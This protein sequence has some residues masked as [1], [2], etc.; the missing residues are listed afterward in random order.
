MSLSL[1]CGLAWTLLYYIQRKC[2]RRGEA[3]R[4]SR[5]RTEGLLVWSHGPKASPG[6][7][8][9]HHNVWCCQFWARQKCERSILLALSCQ[10]LT[11]SNNRFPNSPCFMLSFP[12]AVSPPYDSSRQRPEVSVLSRA[13]MT[14]DWQ[15]YQMELFYKEWLTLISGCF[16]GYCFVRISSYLSNASA[17]YFRK[18]SASCKS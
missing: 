4:G 7:L 11:Q 13:E 2:E 8:T 10:F 15:G 5:N 17:A 16:W 9:E 3:H 6:S 12:S 1:L 18:Y 14:T